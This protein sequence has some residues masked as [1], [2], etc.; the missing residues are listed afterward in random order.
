MQFVS[1]LRRTSFGDH[2]AIACVGSRRVLCINH[3]ASVCVCLHTAWLVDLVT[4]TTECGVIYVIL[5]RIR[6]FYVLTL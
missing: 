3:Q 4:Y 5:E 1:E 6:R 2:L